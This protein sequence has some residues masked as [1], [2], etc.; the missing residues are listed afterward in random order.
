MRPQ[1]RIDAKTRVRRVLTNSF[2]AE[3]VDR[4]LGRVEIVEGDVALENFGLAESDFFQLA[5]RTRAFFHCA[6]STSF[7]Q[8]LPDA[9]AANVASIEQ[10]LR[11][12]RRAALAFKDQFTLVH[13][14]TA[15]VAGET[16]RI[17]D[18]TELDLS[19]SFRNSYEQSKAESELLV[20][21]ASS[22]FNTRIVRPS[23]VVGDSVTGSAS[24]F[25][26]IY[27]PARLF[28][29]GL[30]SV[31]PGSATT[32]IDLV[33][34]NYVAKAM[35][36]LRHAAV[37]SGSCFHLCSGVGRESS[38]REVIDHLIAAFNEYRRRRLG[39]RHAPLLVAPEL[40]NLASFSL[41]AASTTV[42]LV[43]RLLAEHFDSFKH[44]LHFVPYMLSNPRFD[45]QA[46]ERVLEGQVSRPPLFS[47]Y[48]ERL[49]TYCF[50][51]D[52]GKRTTDEAPRFAHRLAL[53][54]P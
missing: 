19:V 39:L 5:S 9:R 12:S 40:I 11:F 17:V 30:L 20:R 18:S 41:H 47:E 28:T 38:L 14:S 10:V 36:A 1:K 13:V 35:I 31:V 4:V 33:P 27:A 22:E 42:R 52:W 46:T 50:L 44:I 53:D 34:V 2:G 16:K 32:P 21:A 7:S 25:N 49:F 43:E 3:N 48:A 45:C 24:A 51:S 37:E 54:C 29:R 15:Y 6:A 26:V 23:M 8:T